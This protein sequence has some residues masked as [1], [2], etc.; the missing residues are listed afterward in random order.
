[1]RCKYKRCYDSPEQRGLL[2]AREDKSANGTCYS[3][4]SSKQL[5]GVIRLDDVRKRESRK[6]I[7]KK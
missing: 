1:M 2:E 4:Q 7:E 5:L 3:Q 6:N